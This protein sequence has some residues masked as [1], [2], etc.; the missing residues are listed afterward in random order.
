MVRGAVWEDVSGGDEGLQAAGGVDSVQAG[1]STIGSIGEASA[2]G[3]LAPIG[4][5]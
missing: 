1:D 4:V 2:G 3:V 5:Y